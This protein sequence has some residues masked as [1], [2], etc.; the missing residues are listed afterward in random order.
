[1][2]RRY[3]AV[4]LFL[5]ACGVS[6]AA[7]AQPKAQTRYITRQDYY[8]LIKATEPPDW[9]WAKRNAPENIFFYD[10]LMQKIGREDD[11]T[12]SPVR[13]KETRSGERTDYGRILGISPDEADKLVDIL[14]DGYRQQR[15]VDDEWSEHQFARKNELVQ[16]YGQDLGEMKAL[17][18]EV[19]C[20][21]V[22]YVIL[23][24]AWE[25]LKESLG[26][27]T[28]K[29]VN[30]ALSEGAVDS[31]SVMAAGA[32]RPLLAFPG[33]FGEFFRDVNGWLDEK[34]KAIARGEKSETYI[35]P[36]EIHEGSQQAVI[37]IAADETR[38][39]NINNRKLRASPSATNFAPVDLE[40]VN[41]EEERILHHYIDDLINALG[42]ANFKRLD[43]SLIFEP[44][45]LGN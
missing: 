26:P 15:K 1:M 21:K 43:C 33:G 29:R 4:L 32:R 16:E 31:V 45:W 10:A 8:D 34:K 6:D 13:S 19:A 5:F 3:L 41:A 35:F 36:K 39:E 9:K 17:T 42:D 27:E 37:R 23:V 25:S 20:A 38:E 40:T 28:M 11:Q 12:R 22:D 44:E 24:H 18:D 14:L 7:S 30:V 2:D